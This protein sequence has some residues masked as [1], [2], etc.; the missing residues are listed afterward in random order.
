MNSFQIYKLKNLQVR[1]CVGHIAEW[2]TASVF[3]STIPEGHGFDPHCAL[4]FFIYS[5]NILVNGT[6]HLNLR[7]DG[8]GHCDII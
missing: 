4:I 1:G 7:Y 2:F 5:Q 8:S 3:G 6:I